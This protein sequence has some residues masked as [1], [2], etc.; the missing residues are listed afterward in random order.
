MRELIIDKQKKKKR[1]FFRFGVLIG[2]Q[3]LSKLRTKYEWGRIVEEGT[4]RKNTGV[5]R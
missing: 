3:L 1:E 5:D 2:Y 4:D